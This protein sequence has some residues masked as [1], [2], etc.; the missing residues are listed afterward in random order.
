MECARWHRGSDGT[1]GPGRG[2]RR[3]CAAPLATAISPVCSDHR[4]EDGKEG[5]SEECRTSFVQKTLQ[6]GIQCVFLVLP[7]PKECEY[8]SY[9]FFIHM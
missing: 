9:S 2:E 8:L 6:L 5:V 1:L 4:P 7:H 3:L